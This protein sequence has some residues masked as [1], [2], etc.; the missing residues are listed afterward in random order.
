[1]SAAWVC[2]GGC[3]FRCE[4]ENGVGRG[5]AAGVCGGGAE[6]RR[7]GMGGGAGEAEAIPRV[8]P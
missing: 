1:M 6:P 4:E 7:I 5:A 8:L 2:S 3:C